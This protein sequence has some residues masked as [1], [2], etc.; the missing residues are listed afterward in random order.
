MSFFSETFLYF[1]LILLAIF[2]GGIFPILTRGKHSHHPLLLSFSAGLMLGSAFLHLIPE[3]FELIGA[4]TSLY[5]LLGLLTLYGFERFITI[6]ACEADHCEVHSL[7]LS[8]FVGLFLH[9]FTDGIALG[10]GLLI[11]RLGLIVF[12]AIF[13]HKAMEALALSSI[14]VHAQKKNL[15]I[16]LA[17]F[18]L[19][20]AIPIGA[21][22]PWFFAKNSHPHTAG[23]ALAFSAGTFLHISL[24]DLLPEVHRHSNLRSRAA[25]FFVFGLLVMAGIEQWI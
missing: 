7:G 16:F 2:V 3:A 9:S 1:V 22:I 19:A 10:A 21:I 11:P 15:S 4:E 25:L 8:A 14:L 18:C 23:I 12:L 24:S 5:V 13:A 20:L 17:N 6:H